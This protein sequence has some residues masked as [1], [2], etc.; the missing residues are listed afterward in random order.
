MLE[1]KIF[2]DY[3]AAMKAKDALKSS[4]L[5]FLRAELINVAF[6]KKK[7][8]L[9]D[10]EVIGVIRKQIKARQDSIEQ[11]KKGNRLDLADKES[12]EL[13]ILK[14]YLPKELPPEEINKIIE[15]AISSTQAA[16]L[17]DMGRVMKQAMEKIAGQADSK[18]VSDLVKEKLSKSGLPK[19]SPPI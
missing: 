18:V 13:E 7:T 12:K 14:I 9:E 10:N 1:E 8:K 11:F 5:S 17:K 16:G 3:K 15:E 6:A 2:D 4:A 19:D